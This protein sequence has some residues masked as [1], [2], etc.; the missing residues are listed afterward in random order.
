MFLRSGTDSIHKDTEPKKDCNTS[1]PDTRTYPANSAI[2]SETD[3]TSTEC[4][5]LDANR[6]AGAA[7]L[8]AAGK[9]MAVSPKGVHLDIPK[10]LFIA[11]SDFIKTRKCPGSI[12]IQFRSGEI[13]GME[14][15]AKKTYRK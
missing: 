4:T 3:R 13:L 15:V 8:D 5:G 12:T 7:R 6:Q 14:S 10:E 11:L 2:Q 9:Y 1:M